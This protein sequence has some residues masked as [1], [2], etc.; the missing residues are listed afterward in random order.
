MVKLSPE[1]ATAVAHL[2]KINNTTENIIASSL[3]EEGYMRLK[4][5][6]E[7]NKEIEKQKEEIKK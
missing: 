6:H 2:A 1:L 5:E 7:C 4:Q 3:L